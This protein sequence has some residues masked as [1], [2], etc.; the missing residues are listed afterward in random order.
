V[1]TDSFTKEQK[2]S[3]VTQEDVKLVENMKNS[4]AIVI[5][6][7]VLFLSPKQ[8]CWESNLEMNEL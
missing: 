5:F 3:K 7:K 4:S 2:L 6:G 8:W 1:L